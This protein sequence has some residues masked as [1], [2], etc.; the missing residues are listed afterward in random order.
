[1]LPLLLGSLAGRA[2]SDKN[3]SWTPP[4]A[5][6][7]LSLACH[8]SPSITAGRVMDGRLVK[9]NS[10]HGANARSAAELEDVPA[11]AWP[12]AGENRGGGGNGGSDADEMVIL[13]TN[14]FL[15]NRY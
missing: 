3:I 7:P 15:P 9:E 4:R 2:R 8:D 12:V 10:T 13:D 11:A 6:G 1:M 14:E 5:D